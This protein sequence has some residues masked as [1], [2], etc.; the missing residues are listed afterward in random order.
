M[1]RREA[2]LAVLLAPLVLGAPAR[3]Q[4]AGRVYRLGYLSQPSRESVERGLQ[5]FLRTLRELGWI[6]GQNL[7]IEYRW[8]EGKTEQLPEL[9]AELVRMK[10]DVI[11]APAGPAAQAAKNAT[12]SIPIVMIFPSDPVEL[13][14][15]ASLARPGGNVTG[16][17][18]T[19][20]PEIFGKQLQILKEAVP[21]ASRIAVLRNLTDKGWDV[22]DRALE[23]AG[24][25]M[26]V[27]LQHLLASG[28]EE[29]DSAFAAMARE[30]AQALLVAGSSTFLVHRARLAALALK[31]R[32]PTMFNFREMVEA[33][34]LMAYAVNMADFTPRAAAYVDKILRGANP[35]DLPV[36]Q[37]TKFE[38]VIN[39]KTAKALGLTIPQPLLLSAET[40]G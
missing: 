18:Y 17:T 37:P 14:L 8:A 10:V 25:S 40:I 39:L 16:T 7:V 21:R 12:N 15:V 28:P 27:R 20:G 1:K 2:G 11:V 3:A 32:L 31:G 34:G 23:N 22:Q 33:G 6:E 26:G 36:E 5:A 30:Q 35:A 19:P 13:G 24:R 9:A 4:V 38:L 29:L